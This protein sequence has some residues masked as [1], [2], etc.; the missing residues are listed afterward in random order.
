[1]VSPLSDALPSLFGRTMLSTAGVV[2]KGLATSFA[3]VA[4]VLVFRLETVFA[5]N[6]VYGFWD[7]LQ[8]GVYSALTLSLL[9]SA[10]FA[11]GIAL[12][13]FLCAIPTLF[14]AP[15]AGLVLDL[16]HDYCMECT[17]TVQ[18]SYMLNEP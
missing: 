13:Q 16:F 18:N 10:H 12:S 17:Y 5:L 11:E 3:P 15:L 9:G 4:L 1:M 8:Y 2:V 14:G 7:G 6:A